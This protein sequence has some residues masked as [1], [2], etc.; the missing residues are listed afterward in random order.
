MVERHISTDTTPFSQFCWLQIVAERD[1]NNSWIAVHF[2]V[3]REKKTQKQNSRA[4]WPDEG[5]TNGGR[6]SMICFF[7]FYFSFRAG[8]KS[9]HQN[10]I[11]TTTRE[12]KSFYAYNARALQWL[13]SFSL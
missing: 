5:A 7:R 2:V 6:G 11:Q 1:A 13:R 3:V 8:E 9:S 12:K 4:I 10:A